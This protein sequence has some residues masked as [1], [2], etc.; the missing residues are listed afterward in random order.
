MIA[1]LFL[2]AAPLPTLAQAD[3]PG[4]DVVVTGDR[5]GPAFW[6]VTEGD[7]TLWLLGV[8]DPLPRRMTWRSASADSIVASADLVLPA[9]TAID[10]AAGPFALV[11]LYLDWR[12][13]RKLPGNARLKDVV[14]PDLYARFEAMRKRYA[15]REN[16]EALR[17]IVAAGELYRRA[18][19]AVDLRMDR[20]VEESVLKVARTH[21]VPIREFKVRIEAPKAVL[22]ELA[23]LPLGSELECLEYTV[24]RLEADVPAMQARA[25]AWA[26]GDVD[27]LRAT[28][29]DLPAK[30]CWDVIELSPRLHALADQARMERIAALDQALRE[31]HSAVALVPL[32]QLL[33]TNGLLET[34]KARGLSVDEP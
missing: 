10:V 9:S 29:V 6:R 33:G 14:P 19:D 17:P 30:S 5:P 25:R 34:F 7:H 18:L 4:S 27:A 3:P 22:A 8:L 11:G 24:R 31:R 21:R 13:M 2:F 26:V 20:Q 1:S 16:Y 23:A 12:K 15:W 28:R 32:D